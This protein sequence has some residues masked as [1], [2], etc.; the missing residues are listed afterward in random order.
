MA[1]SPGID[2]GNEDGSQAGSF[3]EKSYLTN[4]A[5]FAFLL[6]PALDLPLHRFEVG[7]CEAILLKVKRP[8]VI[9]NV[10]T[11]SKRSCWHRSSTIQF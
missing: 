9:A 5:L 2:D 10:V 4:L 8:F 7:R 11:T 3:V 1:P 6:R